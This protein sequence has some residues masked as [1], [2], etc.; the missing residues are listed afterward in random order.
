M[1]NLF[2]F[3]SAK[4]IYYADVL[5]TLKCMNVIVFTYILGNSSSKNENFLE[6]YLDEAF[7]S[8]Q[9]IWR[10][11]ALHHLLSN[12]SSAVNGCRQNEIMTE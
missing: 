3:F 9:Q 11:L 10:N 8:S 12:G 6:M 4:T 1:S 5:D 2:F 7:S